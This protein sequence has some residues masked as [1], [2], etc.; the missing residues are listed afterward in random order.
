MVVL[1]K[2]RSRGQ[3]ILRQL[4]ETV[5]QTACKYF[6]CGLCFV[7]EISLTAERSPDLYS[8]TLNS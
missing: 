5:L 2:I 4:C 3:V 8:D 7:A 1:F 6:V